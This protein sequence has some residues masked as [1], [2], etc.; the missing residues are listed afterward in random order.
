MKEHIIGILENMRANLQG[1]HDA[2]LGTRGE[3][4]RKNFKLGLSWAIDSIEVAMMEIE[5]YLDDVLPPQTEVTDEKIKDYCFNEH[6]Q[7][8]DIAYKSIK[9]YRDNH[10]PSKG[11]EKKDWKCDIPG[12]GKKAPQNDIFC[13]EHRNADENL[14]ELEKEMKELSEFRYPPQKSDELVDKISR[15]FYNKCKHLKNYI[16]GDLSFNW[17]S[18]KDCDLHDI[19]LESLPLGQDG[20]VI[21]D[22]C[23]HIWHESIL[24]NYCPVCGHKFDIDQKVTTKKCYLCGYKFN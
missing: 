18:C 16:T 13:K 7:F 11:D 15:Q 21:R 14:S 10:L 17:E 8:E 5:G 9:W 20:N 23:F 24:I 3:I 2:F 22:I 1:K 6:G 19:E 12:C 4:P